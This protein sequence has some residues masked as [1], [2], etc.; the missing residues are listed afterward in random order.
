[1]G[2]NINQEWIFVD[3]FKKNEKKIKIELQIYNPSAI[4][5]SKKDRISEVKRI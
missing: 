5:L 2:G 4:V 1:L 3:I